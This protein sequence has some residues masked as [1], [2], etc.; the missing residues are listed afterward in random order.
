MELWQETGAYDNPYGQNFG[1]EGE[2]VEVVINHSYA[3]LY[4]LTYPVD[5]KQ[6]GTDSVS[7]QLAAGETIVERIYKKKYTAVWQES[8]FT[9]ELQDAAMPDYRGGF[10]LKGDTVLGSEQEWEPLRRI[11]ACI[12]ADD[13]TFC[14]TL[15]EIA[16]IDNIVD[17]W[18]FYQAIGGFDN[19]NK[20]M[21]YVARKKDNDYYG[22]FIPWDLNISFGA[23]YAENVY[24][25]EETMD[26]VETLV[27]FEPGMR[28]VTLNAGGAAALA[29][30]KWEQ[31][32]S[33]VFATDKVIARAKE[34]QAELID[35]GALAREMERWPDGNTSL[36][37]SL[38]QEFTEKRLDFL[39]RYF[40]GFSSINK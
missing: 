36:D 22:Y 38:L 23:V 27:S 9:G 40:A 32:R 30:K 10:F 4:L 31:W 1:V 26:E 7:S 3:G 19:E 14:D 25:C 8:D 13:Q 39:D 24:Y 33:S 35:S 12:E 18:L 37:L 2:Y 16:D 20:N 21:Y 28:A 11:A 6:V 29:E 17:N 15:P 34:L 5:A